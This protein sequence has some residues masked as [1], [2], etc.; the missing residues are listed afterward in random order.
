MTKTPETK[1]GVREEQAKGQ[2]VC[3]RRVRETQPVLDP[4]D[5]KPT[6]YFPCERFAGARTIYNTIVEFVARLLSSK[7]RLF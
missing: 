6:T 5:L 3:M 1:N 4:L 2:A 7:L